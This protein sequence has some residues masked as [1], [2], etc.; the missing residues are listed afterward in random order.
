M[1]AV[2][3]DSTNATLAL[4]L[5][6]SR[7]SPNRHWVSLHS[8]G[9]RCA[10]LRLVCTH[11]TGGKWSSL[12]RWP[13]SGLYGMIF[14]PRQRPWMSSWKKMVWPLAVVPM[15]Y[16]ETTRFT[17]SSLKQVS[18]NAV[19]LFVE[20]KPEACSTIPGGVFCP[21]RSMSP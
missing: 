5:S 3:S 10:A 2:F 11:I 7:C 15:W 16:S 19:R 17:S 20:V 21:R 6:W 9:S 18:R 8:G 4:T 12:R 1:T 13:V 14:P